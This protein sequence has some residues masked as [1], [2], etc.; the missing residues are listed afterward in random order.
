M[1]DRTE[2]VP[3]PDEPRGE[4]FVSIW[5]VGAVALIALFTLGGLYAA[6]HSLKGEIQTMAREARAERARLEAKLAALGARIEGLERK[7]PRPPAVA[8]AAAAE[9]GA[10]PA[11]PAPGPANTPADEPEPATAPTRH[12]PRP[13]RLKARDTATK[14]PA[15]K[16]P[17]ARGKALGEDSPLFNPYD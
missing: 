5:V 7:L 4:S 10:T 14:R 9:P 1:D 16:R 13:R 6:H 11:E 2:Y 12:R 17:A 8:A 3:R 15:A